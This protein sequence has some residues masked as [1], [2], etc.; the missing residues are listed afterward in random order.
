MSSGSQRSLVRG[1]AVATYCSWFSPGCKA[2]GGCF[3]VPRISLGGR[4][5]S[6][7][8]VGKK[9]GVRKVCSGRAKKRGF[10]RIDE[11][12]AGSGNRCSGLLE[13]RERS[14]FEE[15]VRVESGAI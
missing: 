8:K 2:G 7:Q 3:D 13:G 12:I 14:R 10:P 11:R 9:T 15:I 1:P 4:C 6:G 5:L